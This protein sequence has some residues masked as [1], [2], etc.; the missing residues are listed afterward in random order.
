MS[1]PKARIQRFNEC[2]ND[3]PP[4][5]T[6]DPKFDLT[7]KGHVIDKSERFHGGK[8]IS[9]AE[10]GLSVC[11]K[12]TSN[13]VGSFRTPPIPPKKFLSRSCSKVAPRSIIPT[14]EKEF[15]YKSQHRLADLQV[16]CSNK[17]KTLQEHE[18]Y[19]ENV[20]EE[21]KNLKLQLEES[22]GKQLDVV[23][24]HKRD[25]EIM[26][27]LQQDILNAHNEKYQSEVENLRCQLLEVSDEKQLEMQIRKATEGDLRSHIADS[28]KK[29]TALEYELA[30]ERHT[31]SAKIRS[32]EAQIAELKMKLEK[33]IESHKYEVNVLEQEKFELDSS[34][35]SLTDKLAECEE[36]LNRVMAESNEKA[37]AMIMEAKTAVE[38]EMRLNTERY[39]SCLAQVEMDRV[40]LTEKLVE[41]DAEIT[42]LSVTLEELK[43]SA[44][45][46]ESFGQSL[47]MEL[48]RAETELAEKKEELRAFKDQILSEAA[49]IVARRHRFAVIMAENQSSVAALTNRLTQNNAEGERLQHELKRGEDCINEH[50]DLLNI[51]RNNSEIVHGQVHA[52][53]EELDAK[54]GLVNQLEIDSS[55][56]VES[57]K[58]VFEAKIKDLK[59]IATKEVTKLQADCDAKDAQNV[60]TKNQLH[61]MTNHLN[62][63]EAMLLQL[64]ERTDALELE[65]SRMELLNGKLNEQLK[66]NNVALEKANKLL[67]DKSEISL[68]EAQS[69]I[70]ELSDEIKSLRENE[71][72]IQEKTELLKEE[73]SRREAAEEE[74]RKL[75]G[76][77]ERLRKDYEE[78]S[79]KYAELV[80]HQNHRQ[81]IK[82]VSQL[83]DKINQ[84]EQDMRVKIRTIEQQQRVIEKLKAD[85]KRTH[86]KGK[87]NTIG[88]SKID[89]SSP[90]SSPQ[91]PLTPLRNRNE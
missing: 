25:I 11:T 34:V 43:S 56:E 47:Q 4:P 26:A 27:K 79:E 77:N 31:S 76:Y 21:L 69:K 12:S 19:L 64:E 81:R 85:E 74:V 9:S 59:E 44:D 83:K 48:D 5:G 54:R 8:S 42:R 36:K 61:K 30:D 73:K 50:R 67:E 72:D 24:Q 46:Q 14:R 75:V 90:V 22:H 23:E 57:M 68:H 84:L 38:E 53:M 15:K 28:T 49:E 55:S 16:E 89:L 33:L 88:L 82:H 17:S 40:A 63:A 65:I 37:N 78:I 70:Q 29:I 52:L 62:A 86:I 60:E 7:G 45:T 39:K 2:E 58:L 71:N 35:K 87:E 20:K 41:K 1:F 10:C 66:E 32:L 6:Y 18:K 3:V 80:G 51:M 13:L 91:K